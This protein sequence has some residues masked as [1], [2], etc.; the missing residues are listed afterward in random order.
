MSISLAIA[1]YAI[2]WWIV[3]FA[4]LPFRMGEKPAP[5]GSDPFAEAVGAPSTPKL[6]LKFLVTTIVSA[7]IVGALYAAFYYELIRLDS[8][9]SINLS[10]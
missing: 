1:L 9:P 5:P 7:V 6:K 2:C 3:L 10:K 8:L 4:I